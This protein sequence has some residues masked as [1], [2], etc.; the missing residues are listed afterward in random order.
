[1]PGQA[2]DPSAHPRRVNLGCGFDK[3]D[4][5]VNVDLHSMH[6]PDLV[7]EVTDLRLLPSN[8]YEHAV[9]QDV[10]EH[11]TRLRTRTALREWNRI[12]KEGGT[13]ELRV[14]NV[15]GLVKLLT[16]RNNLTPARQEELLQCLFGTQRYDGDFHQN[17]FT[18]V[19]L[20][21]LLEEA[22]F[23]V[24]KLA[25]VDDWLFHA[26][27][28]K[29][30]H[31]PPSALLRIEKDEDFLRAVYQEMLGRDPDP[32][33][34]YLYGLRLRAGMVREIVVDIIQKSE[35]YRNYQRAA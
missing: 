22:G 21:A 14:P 29:V 5:Y 31:V 1:M 19:Y 28:R 8:Y 24:V 10:L 35:E 2:F 16:Q 20:T 15:V 12:L 23:K 30:A 34:A 27:A 11:I 13:L 33:A 4:G 9:A 17:G 32:E 6:A 18:D 7:S 3:R 25:T 26:L